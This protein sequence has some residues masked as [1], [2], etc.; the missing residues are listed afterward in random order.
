M[1]TIFRRPASAVTRT[2]DLY[3]IA[4]LAGGPQRVAETAFLGLRERGVIRVRG[5]WVRALGEPADHPVERALIALCPRGKSVASVLATVLGGP[6]MAEIEGRLVS[7]GLLTRS[8]HRLTHAGRR[9]LET[10]KRDATLP[11]YVLGG[12]AAVPDRVLRLTVR[13]AAPR[14]S[15]LG[16]N[17]MRMGRVLDTDFST[18]CDTDSATDCDTHPDSGSDAGHFSC[19]GGG[20]D[21]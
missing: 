5:S 11:T 20:G 7:Y 21:N 9:H 15:G 8:R 19:G 17:L 3:D 10:A 12:R 14:P 18:D 2:L 13:E 1:R 6:E 4:H 16:R